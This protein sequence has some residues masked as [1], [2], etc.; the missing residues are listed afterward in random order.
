M[1]FHAA[2][3][4]LDGTLA[5]TLK[6]IGDAMNR[7]LASRGFATHRL[8][9]Y[10]KF[11]G[12]GARTLVIRALPENARDD[13]LVDACLSDFLADYEK[14]WNITSCLYPGILESIQGLAELGLPMAVLSNK[15][16]AFT[17]KC[18][19]MYFPDDTFRV[20]EGQKQGRPKKPDP[21]GA[22]EAAEQL[23]ISPDEILYLGDSGTDM[24]T[25][26]AAGMF[27]VGALWG[28]RDRKELKETGALALLESPGDIL[29]YFKEKMASPTE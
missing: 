1:C 21:A 26:V 17:Q 15:P 4:D 23:G 10:K 20:V 24:K 2:I 14:N 29:A 11:V 27:P 16:H 25:A 7:V 13:F 3:F 5:D 18:V 9:S 19:D 12:D 6:D 22:F 28:F 8:E